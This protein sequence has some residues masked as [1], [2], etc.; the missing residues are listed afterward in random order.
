MLKHGVTTP[1]RPHRLVVLGGSGFV[2]KAITALAHHRGMDV[3]SLSS[4]EVDLRQDGAGEKLAHFLKPED[5]VVFAAAIDAGSKSGS[6]SVAQNIAMACAV[7][8]ASQRVRFSHL[9]YLSSDSVY[10]FET[11]LINEKTPPNPL[12]L[13]GMMHRAR[14]MIVAAECPVP[15]AVLRLTGIYGEGDSHNAYGPNRFL[16]DAVEKKTITLFGK[17][18]EKRDH[19]HVLDAAHCIVE[20]VCHQSHGVLNLASGYSLSFVE[21]AKHIASQTGATIE[22]S[23]RRQPI[24]HRHYDVT[25]LLKSF[26]HFIPRICTQVR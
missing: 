26:P 20:S 15:L 21:V 24:S 16:R 1:Q 23:A 22:Y 18:E 12:T 19:L 9:I 3:L 10:G 17:G 13:Y 8:D 7:V 2:G 6:D 4:H 14:E 5:S 11:G 25:Q